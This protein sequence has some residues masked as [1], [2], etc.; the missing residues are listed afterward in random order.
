[1][2]AERGGPA[3]GRGVR[4][5]T[6]AIRAWDAEHDRQEAPACE[7]GP[8]LSPSLNRCVAAMCVMPPCCAGRRRRCS[9]RTDEFSD[10][11]EQAAEVVGDGISVVRLADEASQRW[12]RFACRPERMRTLPSEG[13]RR[14]QRRRGL[15][16]GVGAGASHS[17][18]VG[19][20]RGAMQRLL[21]ATQHVAGVQRLRND[22]LDRL[23]G[24]GRELLGAIHP[25][26]PGARNGWSM[27]LRAERQADRDVVREGA[28]GFLQLHRVGPDRDVNHR[29]GGEPDVEAVKL[30]HVRLVLAIG[31]HAL[32]P[33]RVPGLVN[34]EQLIERSKAARS[35]PRG[36]H[37]NLPALA[38]ERRGVVHA[39]EVP[40]A[41]D[42]QQGAVLHRLRAI[43][44][45]APRQVSNVLRRPRQQL[46]HS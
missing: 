7:W 12:R 44:R 39:V 40:I 4:G 46:A 43:L 27:C 2:L 14:L 37:F 42:D 9:K 36:E 30:C 25:T 10:V 23:A 19:L 38:H 31:L 34:F 22:S 29:G 18:P 16:F 5:R 20:R 32:A 21:G 11:I 28:L 35:R 8:M 41:A 6:D 17:H 45:R 1:M 24:H 26:R 33:E 13:A 15:N 3:C